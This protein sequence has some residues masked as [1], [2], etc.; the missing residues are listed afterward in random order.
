MLKRMSSNGG[1]YRDQGGDARQGGGVARRWPR[2]ASERS[3]GASCAGSAV[4]VICESIPST[5]CR[6]SGPGSGARS[7]GRAAA[8][9]RR[10]R[11]ATAAAPLFLGERLVPGHS[12]RVALPL[13]LLR[14]L[15]YARRMQTVLLTPR[16]VSVR[17]EPSATPLARQFRLPHG[18]S[19]PTV[20]TSAG[21]R[22]DTPGWMSEGKKMRS[23]PKNN[24]CQTKGEENAAERQEESEKITR[25]EPSHQ[26]QAAAGADPRP[27][28]VHSIWPD[29]GHS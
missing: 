4:S 20:G 22:T 11:R 17:P 15:L 14:A 9:A 27:L 3:V 25:R 10:A 24:F 19:L 8:V 23:R 6:R 7:G 12:P 2:S 26:T 16:I 29:M 21:N 13:A 1:K 18:N 5:T 28:P